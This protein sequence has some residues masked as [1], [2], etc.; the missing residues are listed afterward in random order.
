MI[1]GRST[2]LWIAVVAALLNVLVIVF[3]VPLTA[4]GIA[5]LNTLAIVLIGLVANETNP[6]TV[7][8]FAWTTKSPDESV[9]SSSSFMA[10]SSASGDASTHPPSD[11]PNVG[12]HDG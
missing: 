10:S 1:L 9:L 5:A 8:T 12:N 6:T 3:R 2:A 4:E 11:S 7:P